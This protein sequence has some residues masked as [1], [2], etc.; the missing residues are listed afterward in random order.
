MGRTWEEESVM[1]G[2][3]IPTEALVL[4][5]ERGKVPGSFREEELQVLELRRVLYPLFHSTRLRYPSS[6]RQI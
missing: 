4:E 1:Q 5:R 2:D 6:H 3:A